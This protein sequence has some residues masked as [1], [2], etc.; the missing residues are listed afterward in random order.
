VI[1][2]VLPV[3][4]KGTRMGLPYP[5]E[6]LP[7]RR[8]SKYVPVIDHSVSA[9]L[10]ASPDT[11]MV[12]IHGKQ[13]KPEIVNHYKSCSHIREPIEGFAETLCSILRTIDVQ[14]SDIILYG[15]PDSYYD[16]NPFPKMLHTPG[17]VCGLFVGEPSAKVDRLLSTSNQ[18][19]DIK[20]P[21]TPDTQDWFWG[22]IKLTGAVLKDM[23]EEEM[24][25][26]YDEIGLIL[27]NYKKSLVYSGSY[28]DLGTW[29]SYNRYFTS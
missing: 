21:K 27:N 29:P 23:V 24:F 13:Y 10:E 17:V 6:M 7:Q 14:D 19:F 3:G 22:T 2:G 16:G 8:Q 26:R 20:V 11:H 25:V 4:G 9:M 12:F 28:L 1:Y 18:V 5:K 15:L